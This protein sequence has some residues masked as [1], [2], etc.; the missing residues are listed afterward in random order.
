MV[1]QGAATLVATANG[2]HI[3]LVIIQT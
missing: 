3:R 1:A 2:T